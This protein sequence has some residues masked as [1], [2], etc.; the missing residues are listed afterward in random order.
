MSACRELQLMKSRHSFFKNSIVG[1][2]TLLQN[3]RR[4]LKMSGNTGGIMGITADGNDFASKL[5]VAFQH[6][7]TGIEIMDALSKS[8]GV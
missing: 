6:A 4:R 7:H 2:A 3:L 5:A 1:E 8:A